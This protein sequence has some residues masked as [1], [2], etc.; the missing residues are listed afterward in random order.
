MTTDRALY[1]L[2][3]V[4]GR[5]GPTEQPLLHPDE[6][7]GR[8]PE[9]LQTVV[10]EHPDIA[11]RLLNPLGQ[12]VEHSIPG[13]YHHRYY[14]HQ[15][16]LW[17]RERP[18]TYANPA[19]RKQ[20]FKIDEQ[21]H[22]QDDAPWDLGV[23]L[24]RNIP[25]EA[26]PQTLLWLASHYPHHLPET[27]EEILRRQRKNSSERAALIDTET[28]SQLSHSSSP[29]VRKAALRASGQF[30]PHKTLRGEQIP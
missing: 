16:V 8:N 30:H 19:W 15:I 17:V 27:L 26:A 28:L 14:L 10:E 7:D 3:E 9:C 21:L 25:P 5:Q 29:Q 2:A 24:G 22:N 4:L 20:L 18:A 1:D 12:A 6:Y 23:C 11:N 13:R